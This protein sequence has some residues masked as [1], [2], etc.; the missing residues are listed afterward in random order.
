MSRQALKYPGW[1]G[2]SSLCCLLC[3]VAHTISVWLI[4]ASQEGLE[5]GVAY[6]RP[7]VPSPEPPKPARTFCGHLSPLQGCLMVQGVWMFHALFLSVCQLAQ[8]ALRVGALTSRR[9][10]SSRLSETICR[11]SSCH[12]AVSPY[13]EVPRLAVAVKRNVNRTQGLHEW[14]QAAS[15]TLCILNYFCIIPSCRM[16]KSARGWLQSFRRI[17]HCGGFYL[18]VEPL[19]FPLGNSAFLQMTGLWTQLQIQRAWFLLFVG[20]WVHRWSMRMMGHVFLWK[21]TGVC[22]LR[23]NA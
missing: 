18:C 14:P 12:L 8:V 17:T 21:R 11:V 5:E 6:T 9:I 3:E 23:N 16:G 20:Y 1:A 13:K 19:P 2:F 15:A 4:R 22:G 7:W 10:W